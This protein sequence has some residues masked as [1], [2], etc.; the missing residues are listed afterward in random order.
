MKYL[1]LLLLLTVPAF[2][3]DIAPGISEA[4]FKVMDAQVERAMAAYNAGNWKAFYADFAKMM[5]GIAT[6]QAFTTLYVDNY[7]K[8]YGN[9]KSRKVNPAACSGSPMNAVVEYNAQF[10]KGPAKLQINFFKD[11]SAWKLQQIQI[12]K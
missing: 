12:N 6:E 4:D 2:A 10:D 11:G 5:A 7:K 3:K 8:K 9:Y 1:L